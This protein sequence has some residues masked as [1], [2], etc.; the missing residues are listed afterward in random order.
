MYIWFKFNVALHPQETV[1][2]IK[3][4]EPRTAKS[5]FTQLLRS[6]V[7]LVQI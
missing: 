1:R 7:Y 5:T 4:G 6:D 3:D 2:T